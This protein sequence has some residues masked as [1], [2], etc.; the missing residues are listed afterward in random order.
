VGQAVEGALSQDGVVEERDPLL[1]GPVTGEESGGAAVALDDDLIEVA[2]LGGV[3]AAQPK[4]VHDQQIG[5]QQSA[6]R[7][8]LGVIGP[9][10]A[11]FLEE[12]IGAQEQDL[13]A[14]PTG[15]MTQGGSQ[16]GLAHSHGSQQEDILLAFQEA[17]AEE[18]PDPVAVEGHRSVPVKAFEGLF[19]VEAGPLQADAEVLV[20]APVNLVLQD[21]F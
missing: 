20:L 19:L 11:Q 21:E 4:I 15:G 17:Q 8:V 14:G 18:V 2:G 12:G 13:V 3:Q 6:Q 5:G 16:E 10:L 9:G 7:F 1:D